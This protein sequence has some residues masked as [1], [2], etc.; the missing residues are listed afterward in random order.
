MN[1]LKVRE[2]WIVN[3]LMYS[4]VMKLLQMLAPIID[5]ALAFIISVKVADLGH[6]G[7]FNIFAFAYIIF[8]LFFLAW[9]VLFL[10]GWLHPT[11]ILIKDK[12]LTILYQWGK[13]IEFN[14]D[15]IDSVKYEGVRKDA[16]GI[17]QTFLLFI[18]SGGKKRRIGGV[19]RQA[20]MELDELGEPFSVE[21]G[22]VSL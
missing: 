7:H 13:E 18:E 11:I 16:Y 5:L 22:S 17:T 14:I 3:E 19:S 20:I 6:K 4:N 12:K 2:K 21:S 15:D 10:P 8:T 1:D 9:A